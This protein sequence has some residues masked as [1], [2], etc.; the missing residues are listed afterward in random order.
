MQISLEN[1]NV[2][3]TTEELQE[4]F[5]RMTT[6]GGTITFDKKSRVTIKKEGSLK[7][8]ILWVVIG[9]VVGGVVI[10]ILL[11]QKLQNKIE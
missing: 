6:N 11:N 1:T 10:Y 3:L 7:V 9:V 4:L 2:K 5:D 8:C